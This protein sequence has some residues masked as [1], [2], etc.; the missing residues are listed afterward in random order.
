M[1][2]TRRGKVVGEMLPLDPREAAP[3][4]LLGVGAALIRLDPSL[5]LVPRWRSTA[6]A[7]G[8]W[9]TG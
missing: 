2:L 6:S 3:I 8:T 5:D 7:P 4:R 9:S 1:L